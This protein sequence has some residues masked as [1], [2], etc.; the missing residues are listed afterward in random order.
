MV[1]VAEAAEILGCT[2]RRVQQ[3]FVEQVLKGRQIGKRLRLID[4][5]SVR[6][7]GKKEQ[8]KGRPK[9]SA[10]TEKN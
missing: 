6:A 7:Y 10:V 1:T 5:R 2:P 8:T 9:I 3:L 4:L